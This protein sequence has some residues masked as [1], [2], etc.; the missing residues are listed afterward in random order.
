MDHYDGVR[1][2]ARDAEEVSE[3]QERTQ[4]EQFDGK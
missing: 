4:S 3:S 1:R 2:L